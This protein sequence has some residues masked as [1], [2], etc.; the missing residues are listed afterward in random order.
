MDMILTDHALQNLNVHGITDLPQQIPATKLNISSK[1]FIPVFGNPNQVNLQ[2][3]NTMTTI[4]IAAHKLK[5]I[6]LPEIK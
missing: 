2:I 5:L 1:H 4:S 6:L 3:M